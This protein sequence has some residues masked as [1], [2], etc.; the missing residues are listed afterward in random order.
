MNFKEV[1]NYEKYWKQNKDG[2]LAV[3]ITK[4]QWDEIAIRLQTKDNDINRKDKEIKELKNELSETVRMDNI[5]AIRGVLLSAIIIIGVGFLIHA[6]FSLEYYKIDALK[7][8]GYAS[9]DKI[10]DVIDKVYK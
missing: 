10:G 3:E 2:E 1:E 8:I 7:G 6:S 4:K 5:Q 9:I